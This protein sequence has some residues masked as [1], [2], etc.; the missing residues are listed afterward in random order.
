MPALLTLGLLT[1][2]G[3]EDKLD[4]QATDSGL[5]PS[6]IEVYSPA[7][8]S[9]I[10]ANSDFVVDY[11]VVR[12]KGGDYV[13]IRVDQQKPMRVNSLEGQHL[14]KGLNP[15]GH[16]LLIVEHAADGKKTGGMARIEITAE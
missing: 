4:F 1:A 2:C 12:G 9:V 7:N 8:G 5:P 16:I 13:E 15:G 6:L 10:P 14:I 3:G 11:A